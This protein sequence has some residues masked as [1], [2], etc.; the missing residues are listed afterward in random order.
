MNARIAYY[1]GHFEGP[2]SS[3]PDSSLKDSIFA[4]KCSIKARASNSSAATVTSLPPSLP[5]PLKLCSALWSKAVLSPLAAMDAAAWHSA[6][7]AALNDPSM[8]EESI[9][10]V[11]LMAVEL[12]IGQ[13]RFEEAF[14]VLKRMKASSIDG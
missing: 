5:Q 14:S 9:E 11:Q 6:L 12:F 2:F 4:W 8:D 7:E 10:A 1:L 13:E 3:S